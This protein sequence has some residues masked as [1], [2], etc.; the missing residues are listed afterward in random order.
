MFLSEEIR[1]RARKKEGDQFW[2]LFSKRFAAQKPNN[3]IMQM[4][5]I[6]HLMIRSKGEIRV[7]MDVAHKVRYQ[8]TGDYSHCRAF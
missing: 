2:I 8:E 3:Y 7:T 4:R 5:C 1:G 6:T